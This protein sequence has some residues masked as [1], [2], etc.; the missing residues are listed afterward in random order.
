MD[1]PIAPTRAP[2]AACSTS[3]SRKAARNAVPCHFIPLNEAGST[4]EELET[5]GNER[6]IGE[7]SQILAAWED[8]PDR[9]QKATKTFGRT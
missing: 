5:E 4:I 6:R 2:S 9:S 7:R 8:Q 1:I 3:L